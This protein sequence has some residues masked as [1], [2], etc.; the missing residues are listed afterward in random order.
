MSI[1][2]GSSGTR[3]SGGLNASQLSWLASALRQPGY[4]LPGH[5]ENGDPVSA[6]TILLCLDMGLIE[7]WVPSGGSDLPK[8][9][10]LTEKGEVIA[11]AHLLGV[12]RPSQPEGRDTLEDILHADEEAEGGAAW[13]EALP[14]AHQEE[15]PEIP[16]ELPPLPASHLKRRASEK[17]A[18][19]SAGKATAPGVKPRRRYED[20]VKAS[21]AAAAG[22]ADERQDEPEDPIER[23][24]SRLGTRDMG[25][26]SRNLLRGSARFM[27]AS[28]LLALGF[29][30][31]WSID[32]PLPRAPQDRIAIISEPAPQSPALPR[33]ED[34]LSIEPA[35]GP[36][37]SIAPGGGPSFLSPSQPAT[38]QPKGAAPAAPVEERLPALEDPALMERWDRVEALPD[39]G[40][41][42]QLASLP[43]D[44]G[45]KGDDTAVEIIRLP[46]HPLS[47]QE[48]LYQEAPLH[49][50]YRVELAAFEQAERAKLASSALASRHEDL[51]GALHLEVTER[52]ETAAEGRPFR[53]VADSLA[54]ETAQRL[55]EE[56][57]KRRQ[58]C[59][60]TALAASSKSED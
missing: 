58:G 11:E 49:L 36:E 15:T 12:H 21:I 13:W 33:I 4:K 45:A 57:R 9:C 52:D 31:G 46:E 40:A 34:I 30:L 55:C 22:N 2:G 37:S 29:A 27:G 20:Q 53:V 48:P 38:A 41:L 6:A 5:D 19:A 18:S 32:P 39:D 60:V 43:G 25:R 56:L 47:H 23:L 7:P 10:R 50:L 54:M 28:G 8:V 35:A 16:E 42:R 17:A 14:G 1:G 44:D 3:G 51:L 59:H 24:R 26:R